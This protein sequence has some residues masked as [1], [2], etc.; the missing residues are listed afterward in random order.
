M[1]LRRKRD[2]ELISLRSLRLFFAIFA[3]KAFDRKVR[4]GFAKVAKKVP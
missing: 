2:V 4:K 3:V 1:R